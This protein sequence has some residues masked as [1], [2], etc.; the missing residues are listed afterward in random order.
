M[1]YVY[2]T[3]CVN[4][5]MRIY[6]I[7]KEKSLLKYD[8]LYINSILKE[9]KWLGEE[10]YNTLKN[11]CKQTGIINVLPVQMKEFPVIVKHQDEIIWKD[12][13]VFDLYTYDYIKLGEP[14]LYVKDKM[15]LLINFH[16][17]KDVETA[18]KILKLLSIYD[19]IVVLYDIQKEYALDGERFKQAEKEFKEMLNYYPMDK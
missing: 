13:F 2:E 7:D 10:Q 17:S 11:Q 9:L 4:G 5:E 18:N 6:R 1:E 19:N 14:F 3:V 16:K 12:T 8:G 15:H